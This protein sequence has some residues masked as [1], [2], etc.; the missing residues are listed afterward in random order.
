MKP[1]KKLPGSA[2]SHGFN[3]PPLA[4]GQERKV[5]MPRK[6]H[7]QEPGYI[8]ER[9]NPTDGRFKVVIYIAA[10]QGIDVAP[11]KYAVVCDKH[12]TIVGDSSVSGAR[13]S[14]KAPWNFCE[15]CRE[16]KE[17]RDRHFFPEKIVKK[18][19]QYDP[20]AD[21]IQVKKMKIHKRW[22]ML[23]L[24]S[25]SNT[26]EEKLALLTGHDCKTVEELKELVLNWE[27]DFFEIGD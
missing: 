21:G 9:R 26:D 27:G 1:L 16:D 25:P 10:D 20:D 6:K 17:K 11:N 14:M 13:A 19:L 2:S 22:I 15:Q 3:L 23:Q 8:A 4:G 12:G 5:D 7:N 24:N 18:E